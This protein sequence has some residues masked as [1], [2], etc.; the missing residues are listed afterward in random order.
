[1]NKPAL[2]EPFAQETGMPVDNLKNVEHHYSLN[3]LLD[4]ILRALAAMGKDIDSLV[5]A[6]L[7]PVDEFHIRGIEATRELAA[8]TGIDA[9]MRVLDVG[10]GIG[11]SARHLAAERGCHVTGIDLTRDYIEAATALAERTGLAKRVEFH[12]GSATELPYEPDSFDIVW[13][14]HVQ[15]NIADKDAF[16]GEITR[17]LKPGGRLLFH[18]IFSRDG[19]EPWYPVPWAVDA[20]ISFLA[21]ADTVPDILQ[22]AGLQL[23]EWEDRSEDSLAWFRNA[24]AQLRTTGP[25]SL[26]LHLL[27]G[28]SALPKFEN[29]I[30]NLQES[31][32]T[33]IQSVAAKA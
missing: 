25:T 26:G 16:Y 20:S 19:S 22:T 9:G 1:V 31:R 13:T 5:P 8:R 33:V 2:P 3:E 15:M 27:M 11:G 14:E 18:D 32:I 4:S 17:V 28:A 24:V 21:R 12:H 23:L 7:A 6:D 30:R 29:L 10:C